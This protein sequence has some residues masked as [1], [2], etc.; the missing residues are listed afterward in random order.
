MIKEIKYNGFTAMPSDYQCLDGDLAG[1]IG[2][3]PEEE[4]L[5]PVFPPKLIFSLPYGKGVV[6]I[7]HTSNYNHYI[8]KDDNTNNLSW[9]LGNDTFTHLRSF[10]DTEIYQ[11][12]AIGNTL[13]A[14]ASDGTHYFLWKGGATG[15]LYLGTEIPECP[16]AFGLQGEM[17]S[18]DE[19]SI[20]FDSINEGDI[21]NE[22]SDANKSKITSQ[23][24]AKVNKFISDHSTSKGKFIYP[25]LLRYAYR[26]YDGTLTKHSAPVL[27][28]CSS[29]LAP[30]VFYK[31]IT[32]KG[33]YTSATLQVAGVF[34][35]LD[36]AVIGEAYIT[37]LQNWKDIVRSVDIFV[38]KPVYTY[39]QNGEC[40]KFVNL[41][42]SDS[43][44][45][46][47]HVNQTAS[48]SLYPLRYQKNSFAKLYEFTYSPSELTHPA[49]RLM[50][51]QRSKDDVKE[52]IKSCAQFY[53]L[54]SI[55]VEQ[56]TTVRTLI[57]VEEDYLQS[58]VTR[59]VMSDDYDSHDK[60]IPRY[61]FV[62]NQRLNIT[63]IKKQL[64]DGFNGSALF[65]FSDGY[66][67]KYSPPGYTDDYTE[68]VS[69]FVYIKQ[70]GKDIVVRGDTG[71]IGFYAPLLYF[72]YPNINAYKAVISVGN[73]IPIYY[74]VPLEQHNFLNGAFYFDGWDYL[75][76]ATG[77][78][79]AVSPLSDTTID[80]PNKIYTSEI[81][82]PFSYPVTGVNT[83]G[84]GTIL[85][86]CAAVKA[87]S[88][89]QFGQFPL[90]AFT[91]E[92]VWAMEVSSTGT[93]SAK[94][95]VTRDVCINP[96]S[97][98]QID[99][100]VLF[101]TR[102]GIMI[103]SGSNSL[104]LSDTID[105]EE[106]FSLASLPQSSE[107]IDMAGFTVE[108]FNYLPFREFLS[109]CRMLYDYTHQR[110]I[111]YNTSCVYAYIY[112]LESKKWGMMPS[113]IAYGVNSYPEAF[114]MTGSGSLVDFSDTDI[115]LTSVRG[116]LVTRPFKLDAP[117]ILKTV[118]TIIQRG[119]FR[120]GHVQTILYGSRD[121]FNWQLIWSS[122]DHYLRGFRGS[123]YKYFCIV[124]LCNL[125]KGESIFSCTVQY[126]QRLLNQ[127]R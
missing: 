81:N 39:D 101:A 116:L 31:H 48:T 68:R 40:T 58:L 38:S 7:H 67:D 79:P 52:D 117:D 94:Q 32:G 74:E 21:W 19:F 87:L 46:C 33:S 29:D 22:F 66:V 24:L 4:S 113:N 8:V 77:D 85:G 41:D 118:D 27:M 99:S 115:T 76:K 125:N 34:H 104:C 82:N 1:V 92:G 55:K 100:A 10:S 42:I 36:Y 2:L 127:P 114:A 3:I 126:T 112:S 28:V 124:L 16:I 123:A 75:T 109:A 65:T 110:I 57:Q 70:D 78:I 73:M 119:R 105:A 43:Y 14:L 61:S 80:I 106:Y 26:L 93:Y 86:I 17:K 54:E 108:E 56:L 69:V 12:N 96:D 107:I 84:T 5:K 102:R 62:Y 47:K 51:P 91:T 122:A 25:F 111:V 11:V 20:S 63:N 35:A 83:V 59:E 97:I 18:T 49:G 9:T 71:L 37:R 53:F 88:Q 23:V 90:Y 120:K 121:L 72:F 64:F 50:I 103:I 13:I 44:C 45:I 98:T 15:Y 6:F 60:L 30:Q 95:P 89:G